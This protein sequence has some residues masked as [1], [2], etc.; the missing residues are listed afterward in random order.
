MARTTVQLTDAEW[1]VM[2]AVWSCTPPVRARDVLERVVDRTAWSYSTVKTML[3]RL[4]EKR[5]LR[6]GRVGNA[7]S[8]EPVLTRARARGSALEALVSRAFGGR[9]G[10]LVQHMAQEERLS[11]RDRAALR[12]LLDELD[13][14]GKR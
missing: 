4:V 1:T 7:A 11:A 14:G 9:L 3:T 13:R 6:E 8:Y 5:V 2:D 10:A 12:E